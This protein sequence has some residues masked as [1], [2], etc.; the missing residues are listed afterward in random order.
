[1]NNDP[2]Q[3]PY[4]QGPYASP[5][6]PSYGYN[7][8]QSALLGKW[9]WGAFSYGWIWGVANH[10]YIA[11]I[12]LLPIPIVSTVMSILL[13]IYGNRWA[14]EQGDVKDLPTFLAI[15]KTWNIAGLICFILQVVAV[16]SA[17]I[18]MITSF[19]YIMRFMADLP[20]MS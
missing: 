13:G 5:M 14:F 15:Q 2:R 18:V 10:C 11:L 4:G 19:A 17:I 8:E 16:L 7:P 3:T 6:P 1:M 12:L 20:S 9:N